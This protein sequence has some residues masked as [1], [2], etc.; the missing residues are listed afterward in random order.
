MISRY[1]N[2]FH[3]FLTLFV[4]YTILKQFDRKFTVMLR[5]QDARKIRS[6]LEIVSNLC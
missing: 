2:K 6:L 3:N 4:L 5:E 1:I